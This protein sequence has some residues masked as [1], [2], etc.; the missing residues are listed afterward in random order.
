VIYYL[1]RTDGVIWMLTMYP[2][3]IIEDA[4]HMSFDGFGRR[5][6]MAKGKRN[7]GRDIL[8]GLREIR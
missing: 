2:K 4:R 5:L 6:R 1:K 7:I 3:N 8:E